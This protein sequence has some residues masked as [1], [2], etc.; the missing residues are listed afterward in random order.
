[1]RKAEPRLDRF[2]FLIEKRRNAF[3]SN[4]ID[5]FRSA[6]TVCDSGTCL[7]VLLLLLLVTD[8]NALQLAFHFFRLDLI[9]LYYFC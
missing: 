7:S 1:M 6:K 3:Q 8:L 5:R 4:G 2:G 9:I